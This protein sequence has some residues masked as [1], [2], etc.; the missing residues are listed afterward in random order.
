MSK[1]QSKEFECFIQDR[2]NLT[3]K[4]AMVIVLKKV[5]QLI[6]S[7]VG[8]IENDRNNQRSQIEARI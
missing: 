7:K 4:Q 8:H 5:D 6:S 2:V 3:I 1:D